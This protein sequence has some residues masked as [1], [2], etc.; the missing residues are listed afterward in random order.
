MFI[1]YLNHWMG[2][3]TDK[4][5][6]RIA[7]IVPFVLQIVVVVALVG[8]FSWRNGQK[9]VN[10]FALQL[11][12]QVTNRIDRHLESYLNAP[13]LFLEINTAAVRNGILDI[14]DFSILQKHFWSEI[15]LSNAI[16][17]LFLGDEEGNFMGVQKYLDRRNPRI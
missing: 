2:K 4:I 1:K 15:Q 7:P 9:T 3:L 13:H 5:P 14:E 12:S 11:S 17:Y 10:N 6:L 8:Y 16:E